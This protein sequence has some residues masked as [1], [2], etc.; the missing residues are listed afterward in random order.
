MS[1]I[2]AT[3]KQGVEPA[4]LAAPVR[5]AVIGCGYW[6][7]N[8]LRTF[9]SL[10]GCKAA[11]VADSDA[12]RLSH[13]AEMFPQVCAERDYGR[14][15]ADPMID[16]VIVATPTSTHYQVVRDALNAGKHVLCEKPMCETRAH[17]AELVALAK[18]RKLVLMVGHVFLFNGG[19]ETVK[20]LVDGGELGRLYY[21]SS[22]RTNLGPIRSDVNA[23]YDLA[24]HDIS[25]F[26][27]ILGAEPKVISA[28]GGSFLQPGIED[29]VFITLKYP[30]NVIA[31]IHASW[32][33][34]KKVRNLTVVGSRKMVTWDD[35][36]LN[37]PVAIYDRGANAEQEANGYGEFLRISMWSGDVRLPKVELEEPLKAQAREFLRAVRG[38]GVN[39]SEGAFG[40]G[41]VS[42]LE[43]IAASLRVNG[44]PVHL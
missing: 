27:W 19:I 16:A 41:V 32:L 43:A 33:N 34:P 25:L 40:M 10:P 4:P 17:A 1:T 37:T 26:N 7:P 36:E 2:F 22:V 39:R 18:E 44:A 21:L 28:T 11:A 42:T 3:V 5:I 14:V 30:G 8:H 29:A 9:G 31:S 38:S 15:L 13:V 20:K 12:N 6:G 23:A 24:A 35:L